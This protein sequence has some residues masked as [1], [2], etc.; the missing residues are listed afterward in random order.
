M[1][2]QLHYVADRMVATVLNGQ[3][4]SSLYLVWC[5]VGYGTGIA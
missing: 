5:L 1:N 3:M 4:L 2:N